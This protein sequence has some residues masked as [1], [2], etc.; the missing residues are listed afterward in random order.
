MKQGMGT[1]LVPRLSV[2][3]DSIMKIRVGRKERLI[4]R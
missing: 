2:Q 1:L 3:T 4:D